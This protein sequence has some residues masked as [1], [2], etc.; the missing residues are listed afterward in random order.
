MTAMTTLP[1]AATRPSLAGYANVAEP[2]LAGVREHPRRAAVVCGG[3]RRSYA[4]TN[5]RINRI[6]ALLSARGVRPGDQVAYLLPNCATLIE[7]YYAIQKLGAVAVPVNFRSIAPELA[8]F[9]AASDASVLLFS[10]QYAGTVAAVQGRIPGVRLQLCVDGATD[11]ADDLRPLLVGLSD[12]EPELFMDANAVSRIQ[13]TGGSTGAPKAAERTHRAD[14]VE[15]EGVYGSNGLYADEAKVVLIQCPLEHHGGHSWFGSSLSLGATLVL[16]SSFDPETILAQIE[17]HRVSYMI[18]LPPTTYVRLMAHPTIGRYD[19]SSVRLVQSSAGGTS[20][21]IVADIYRHFPHAVMNYGWGQTETGLG[22]SLVLTREMAVERRPRIQSIGTPMPLIDLKVVDETGAEVAP[23]VVGECVARSDALLRGYHGQPELTAAGFTADGWWRTG[24]LMTRDADGYLYLRGRKRELVKSGGENVFVGE[25]ENVLRE[26]PAILDA[27]VY[28]QEDPVL[29]EAVAAAV[30]LRP[31]HTLTLG[32]L[33]A[34]CRERL[35]SFKKPRSLTVLDS[36]DRDFSGKLRRGEVIRRSRDAQARQAS[37]AARPD[38]ATVLVRVH[39]DPEVWRVIL[40]MHPRLAGTTNAW[41]V[42]TAAGCLLV[43][44]GAPNEVA[45]GT[46]LRAFEELGIESADVFLTHEHAD[47]AGLVTRWLRDGSRLVRSAAAFGPGRVHQRF[48]AAGFAA[49]EVAA[50]EGLLRRAHPDEVAALPAVAATDGAEFDLA[51][52][53]A[54]V[55]ATPGH[56]DGHA[57]LYL[58]DS[59]LLFAGDHVLFDLPPALF[60]DTGDPVHAYFDSLAKVAA[61]P[62]SLVLPGHGRPRGAEELTARTRR[63]RSHHEH[64][65]ADLVRLVRERPGSTAAELIMTARAPR[66]AWTDLAVGRRWSIASTTLARLD[67]LVATGAVRVRTG[68][69]GLDHYL[70][71]EP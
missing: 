12:A 3:E 59:G 26:H 44:P 58:P 55:V 60:A 66:R 21:E 22:S 7:V 15:F 65:L 63:L 19:L 23:G 18:L 40:P 11:W 71:E 4:D 1:S 5:A 6:C 53:P 38:L 24:D 20:P 37:L 25:V 41:L 36:L 31:G 33:Q 10:R 34:F 70:A 50:Y 14:L 57:C 42:R 68:P 35:A 30:E 39:D 46:L 69:D 45:H 51:G 61:L 9:L 32:Q 13:F 56:T 17:R 27:M 16:C 49:D 2:F 52:L 28:G 54:R 47:H 64:R 67:H 62:V 48:T 43:D 29:G 8:Y